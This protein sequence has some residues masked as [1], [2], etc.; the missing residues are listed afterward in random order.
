[1]LL[2]LFTDITAS[3][4][5]CLYEA[6]L[7][8]QW[9][10]DWRRVICLHTAE[11]PPPPLNHLQSVP[12]KR[13]EVERFL[14]QLFVDTTLTGL[15]RPV[16]V[17]FSENPEELTRIADEIAKLMRRETVRTEHL[18]KFLQLEI[19]QPDLLESGGIPPNTQV[20][21]N[22]ES[23]E[24]FSKKPGNWTWP[25]LEIGGD[26]N[27]DV[28]WVMQLRQAMSQAIRGNLVD[29]IQATF[30]SRRDGRQYRPLL[31]SMDIKADGRR[32]FTI[33]FTEDA[34]WQFVGM[35]A[36][37]RSL[38][39]ALVMTVRFRHEVLDRYRGDL[40]ERFGVKRDAAVCEEIRHAIVSIELEAASHGLTQRDVLI[41]AFEAK[42]DRDELNAMYDDWEGLRR[43]L[44]AALEGT[45]LARVQE[46]LGTLRSS[47][48]RFLELATRRHHEM[49]QQPS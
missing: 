31:H 41:D 5:W 3:W 20:K 1:M 8:T 47:N 28:R 30:R 37:M 34:S 19:S 42:S 45:Q 29:P 40:R 2:L 27:P 12:A 46:L 4:D 7:F 21:S 10:S 18:T 11:T 9:D 43:D 36:E 35:S 6:G 39:I 23:L 32:I 13:T 17:L 49:V 24:I 33:L 26:S 48:Q 25:Q 38:L 22:A 14:R 16:N 15:D 44:F